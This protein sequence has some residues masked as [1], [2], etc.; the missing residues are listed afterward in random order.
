[1]CKVYFNVT[2][3]Q[4]NRVYATLNIIPRK[5][6]SS[7]PGMSHHGCCIFFPEK[8]TYFFPGARFKCVSQ[9]FALFVLSL[10]SRCSRARIFFCSASANCHKPK[11]MF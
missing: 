1:M 10:T 4:L 6:P 2:K 9:N 3:E 8:V 11:Q 7:V 5:L